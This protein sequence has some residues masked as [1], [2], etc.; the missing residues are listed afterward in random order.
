MSVEDSECKI[1]EDL[2]GLVHEVVEVCFAVLQQSRAIN[3]VRLD[4]A[5]GLIRAYGNLQ[6]HNDKPAN[7]SP[8]Q[9]VTDSTLAAYR[10]H[11]NPTPAVLAVKLSDINSTDH[12]LLAGS[13]H[14]G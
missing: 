14:A 4:L 11:H 1:A 12:T 6:Q 9:I 3:Q 5:S 2:C 10:G 7:A 8:M 13:N